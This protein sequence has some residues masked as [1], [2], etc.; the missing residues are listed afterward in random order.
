MKK[1][2]LLLILTFCSLVSN[3]QEKLLDYF[4][5]PLS[6]CRYNLK[7]YTEKEYDNYILILSY[8]S[9]YKVVYQ[10]N[11]STNLVDHVYL[12]YNTKDE[13]KILTKSLNEIGTLAY[14]NTW[15]MYTEKLNLP[16]TCFLDKKNKCFIFK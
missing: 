1:I 11:K 5:Q 10:V 9:T 3:A 15:K 8:F 2:L 16:V 14:K 6:Y 12:I 13:L 7:T 4:G